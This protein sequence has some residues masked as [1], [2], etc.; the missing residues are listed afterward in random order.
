MKTKNKLLL[1]LM[2]LALSQTLYS[3]RKQASSYKP[4]V[5]TGKMGINK[6]ATQKA[7]QSMP[8]KNRLTAAKKFNQKHNNKWRI[9]FNN[10]KGTISSI[11]GFKSKQYAGRAKDALLKFMDENPDLLG[12]KNE[13]LRYQ[14]ETKHKNEKHITYQ[15][16]YKGIPIENSY[17]S[18]HITANNEIFAIFSSYYTDI[19]MEVT[20]K[21][22]KY[23]ATNIVLKNIG[24]IKG[25]KQDRDP[26]LMILP[27]ELSGYYL[28]WKVQFFANEPLGNWI[29]Y[30]DAVTGEL[31]SGY[32]NMK[33]YTQGQVQG[34]VFQKSG[35]DT[36]VIVSFNNQNVW[37]GSDQTT[38]DSNGKYFSRENDQVVGLLKGPFANVKND[39]DSEISYQGTD[40]NINW[41]YEP[42][43][44]HFNEQ[45]LFYHMNKIHDYYKNTLGFSSI[46]LQL[47]G[48]VN[49]N[50]SNA[51]FYETTIVF[52]LG[53]NVV[54]RDFAR[55]VMVIYHEYT[56]FVQY[57]IS[58]YYYYIGQQGAMMEAW[59]DYFPCSIFDT[60]VM[61]EYISINPTYRRNLVNEKKFP[62][63]MQNE[64]HDDS[65]IYSGALWDIR[66]SL[67]SDLTDRL[68]FGSM[69]YAPKT[70]YQGMEAMLLVDDNDY[71]LSNGTP[72]EAAIRTAFEKHGIGEQ[73]PD[74]WEEPNDLPMHHELPVLD[75][76]MT[77]YASIH[78]YEDDDFYKIYVS[79]GQVKVN[80]KFDTT[81][82]AYDLYIFDK[83]FN[84]L[85]YTWT[86]YSTSLHT[87]TYT[88]KKNQSLYI[89]VI[90]WN[91]DGM[92][93]TY[94]IEAVYNQN[95]VIDSTP[96]IG[97]PSSPSI[98]NN[99]D[100]MIISWTT[101]G[102]FDLDSGIAGYQLQIGKEENSNDIFDGY[103]GNRCFYTIK[104]PSG[105]ICYARV[106]A[107]NAANLYSAW[108]PTKSIRLASQNEL[109][110]IN[111]Y[112]NPC[113]FE[114]TSYVSIDLLPKNS[115]NKVNIYSIAGTCVRTL[116]SNDE[117]FDKLN[118]KI[119]IWDGKNDDGEK[120]A[121]G[122]YI[123]YV[124][125][126]KENK[127]E[128]IAIFW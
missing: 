45:H 34:K 67:G 18:S 70:F 108:S 69:F 65:V 83:E 42:I 20:P 47:E 33:F 77:Y 113:Y 35:H 126:D 97:C 98:V 122:L 76:G 105:K 124:K 95:A 60:S 101:N 99:Y 86:V 6:K 51:Y 63:D 22:T 123:F 2:I 62:N 38:T 103:I 118:S 89:A 82:G 24:G 52:G 49:R 7:R 13:N 59:S 9:G 120:V 17:V 66:Q 80:I 64:V 57:T 46:D 31:L 119:G 39:I 26:E 102:C 37:I 71:D 48:I 21:I 1:V 55:D 88:N 28:C 106:R 72:H 81:N 75:T 14:N 112:P 32:N 8:I 109:G 44:S 3:F 128:K 12:I 90:P 74:S 61:G 4:P 96:P 25:L 114:R 85:F 50:F 79:S 15:Q 53:D 41:L 30:V 121:S 127:K 84:T 54:W 11:K 111:I 104:V 94:S 78:G 125:T 40:S 5:L 117:I 91:M 27:V 116:D 87:L 36:P 23:D 115:N 68:V 10:K 56:H 110:S 29:H 93:D 73:H 16:D 19:E 92:S 107:K 58:P 43:E 100:V